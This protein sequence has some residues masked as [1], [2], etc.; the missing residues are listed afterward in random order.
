MNTKT[1]TT[2]NKNKP[3]DEFYNCK[4][5]SDGKQ[6]KCKQ[7]SK[8]YGKEW[9]TDI[10]PTYHYHYFKNPEH[11]KLLKKRVEKNRRGTT[12]KVYF[13]QLPDDKVYVGSTT[14]NIKRRIDTHVNKYNR[15]LT[16]KES[17][18][19]PQLHQELDKYIHTEAIH[20]L[21]NNYHVIE[22]WDGRD[23]QKSR[24]REQ[25]WLEK[26]QSIHFKTLNGYKACV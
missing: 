15:Y 18:A 5:N 22:E 14:Q 11:Y 7:C 4:S 20:I 19:H 24:E 8:E 12:S 3:L 1:C 16:D 9:R 17:S 23:R 21:R 6:Y 10:N 13:I 26:L 2:C 25:Y